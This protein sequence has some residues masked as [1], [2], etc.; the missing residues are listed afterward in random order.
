MPISATRPRSRTTRKSALRSV[1]RRCETRKTVRP[2]AAALQALEDPR[3]RLRVD[4]GER[5]VEDEDGRVRQESARERRAL[6]LAAGERD[7]ALAHDRVEA[8]REPRD[9]GREPR[10]VNGALD[11]RARGVRPRERDVAA[12]VSEKRNVSCG[13]TTTFRRRTGSGISV[14]SRPPMKTV[15]TGG[16]STRRRR[17]RSVDLPAPVRPTMATVV[18]GER[19][20]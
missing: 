5:V 2:R 18:P 15:P 14:R 8:L 3:L 6:L 4:G 13:T 1:E 9:V 19:G 12:S 16:S 10:G 11:L 20:T 7:A 17:F